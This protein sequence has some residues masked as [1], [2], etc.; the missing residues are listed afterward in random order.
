MGRAA[1]A[2]RGIKRGLLLIG[3]A[4]PGKDTDSIFPVGRRAARMRSEGLQWPL[5]GLVFR[6][7]FGGMSNRATAARV[8]ITV[9]VGRL[10]V[11]RS[12][13]SDAGHRMAL[14][15]TGYRVDLDDK[16]L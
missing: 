11:M 13:L 14:N 12:F 2:E 15:D 4:G 16:D 1:G 10:L 5:D 3:G 6:P 9:G 8:R 7:G